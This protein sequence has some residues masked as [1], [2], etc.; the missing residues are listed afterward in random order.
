LRKSIK[1]VR[2]KFLAQVM[3]LLHNLVSGKIVPPTAAAAVAGAA[4]PSSGKPS[5]S[6]SP[7]SPLP[8]AQSPVQ[9]RPGDSANGKGGKPQMAVPNAGK[10]NALPQNPPAGKVAAGSPA[11]AQAENTAPAPAADSST[12]AEDMSVTLSNEVLSAPEAQRKAAI[13]RCLSLLRSYVQAER[14]FELSGALND[15]ASI[16]SVDRYRVNCAPLV[17]SCACWN[18][19]PNLP[20]HRLHCKCKSRSSTTARR[21]SWTCLPTAPLQRSGDCAPRCCNIPSRWLTSVLTD[22]TCHCTGIIASSKS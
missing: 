18:T 1:A 12:P 10:A 16:L 7:A 2:S 13:Q 22:C 8:A 5:E 17:S 14:D 6:K 3:G 19:Q 15:V 9:P 21:R 11:V 20:K 4:Q